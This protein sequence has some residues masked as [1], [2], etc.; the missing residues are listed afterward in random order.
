MLDR[1]EGQV[2]GEGPAFVQRGGAVTRVSDRGCGAGHSGRV[3]RPP[4]CAR[5]TAATACCPLPPQLMAGKGPRRS[6]LWLHRG[7]ACLPPPAGAAPA[8]TSQKPP[9]LMPSCT[10]ALYLVPR[11]DK[12]MLGEQSR[13][14][15]MQQA[16]S[17][18][19]PHA[20]GAAVASSPT[21]RHPWPN[22][23]LYPAPGPLLPCPGG[24]GRLG[25][26]EGA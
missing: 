14:P 16:L 3:A 23:S 5:D 13:L 15:C 19:C 26:L 2:R 22:Q 8:G 18:C 4:L 6:W 10:P 21:T 20:V 24:A 9:P 12:R 7:P 1:R 25:V 11:G 17:R